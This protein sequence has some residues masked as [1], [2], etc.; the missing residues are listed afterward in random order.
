MSSVPSP[1]QVLLSAA[2]SGKTTMLVRQALARPQR[3]I[4]IITY[5]LENLE[6]I[7]QAFD[8]HA[9]TVPV[10]VTLYSWYGFLLRECIRPYQPALCA[11]PRVESFLFVEGRTNNRAPRTQVARHYLA[12]DK[13]YSDRAADFAV[14]CDELTRGK[15]IERLTA[16]YD[17]VY[18]DEI[19]DLAGYDLDLVERLLTS[20]IEITLVGDIRQATY[21][22]NHS[23]RHQQYRGVAMVQLF[24]DWQTRNLCQIQHRVVSHRCAQSLCDLADALYPNLPR[25]QSGN[26]DVTGHDGIYVVTPNLVQKYVLQYAPTVLRH[27]R[28]ETC[29]GYSAVNFGQAKGRTYSRVLIYPN[30]P[31]TLFLRTADASRITSPAR[32]YVAL[33]RARQSVAFVMAGACAWPGHQVYES[34]D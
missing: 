29:D 11:Q 9:G 13:M 16:M 1:N 33:T 22:T 6:E 28:R 4:A 27:D 26:T 3:R 23:P 30:G 24:Q 14:R 34:P 32:Y 20:G 2:G 17:E 5:T 15:V 21:A 18:I 8:R 25:T 7:R 12:G 10:H 31:L 19:Q